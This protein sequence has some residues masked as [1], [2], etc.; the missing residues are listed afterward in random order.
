M[1]LIR[2]TQGA[3]TSYVFIIGGTPISWRL[4]KHTLIATS[5]NHD[6]ILA[7]HEA[8]REC[9]WL[10]AFV[11]NIQSTC[12]LSTV[13]VPIAIFGDNATC[14]KQLKKWYIKGDNIKDIAPK[15]F[16]PHQQ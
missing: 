8:I 7:L 6:E 1:V 14:I 2:P 13:I 9:F 4:T 12:E 16:F 11:K 5:S 3:Q 15:F 10:R